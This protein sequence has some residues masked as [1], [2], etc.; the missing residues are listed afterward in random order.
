MGVKY[1][2]EKYIIRITGD[3]KKFLQIAFNLEDD[4]Q[5]GPSGNQKARLLLPLQ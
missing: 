5:G 3:I 4:L 1:L 2:A